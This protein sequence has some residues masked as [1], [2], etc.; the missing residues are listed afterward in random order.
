MFLFEINTALQFNILFSS[1]ILLSKCY[2]TLI[3]IIVIVNYFLKMLLT[4][5]FRMS[6]GG[7][8]W[9]H[10]VYRRPV[11]LNI[12]FVSTNTHTITHLTN[13]FKIQLGWHEQTHTHKQ[14]THLTTS[15]RDA[16]WLTPAH[17]HTITDL[18]T[19]WRDA[20]W[21]TPAH[22]H[23]PDHLMKRCSLADTST[24][25]HP[26]TWPPHEEM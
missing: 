17:T 14:I 10:Q 25:T 22:T 2:F 16:A 20:A 13:S 1:K 8:G 11:N 7:W 21:L 4:S 18:T 26:L 3:C 9:V 23:S 19:S 15:W 12:L 5:G 6:R 24:H